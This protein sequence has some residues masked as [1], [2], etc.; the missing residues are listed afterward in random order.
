MNFFLTNDDGIDSPNLRLLAEMT[1]PFG[2]V[3]VVAPEKQ[4]S[5]MSQHITVRGGLTVKSVQYPVEGVKA[6]TVSGTPAD[7]VKVGLRF[8]VEEKPDY[9]FSGINM[10]INTGFDMCYSGT[11]AAALEGAMSGVPSIAWSTELD[12]DMG[13]TKRYFPELCKLLLERKPEKGHLWNVNFPGIPAAECKGYLL[14]RFPACCAHYG[15]DYIP[16]RRPDGSL[17]LDTVPDMNRDAEEGSDLHAV[18]NGYVAVG[19]FYNQVIC[20]K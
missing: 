14:D 16:E 10:G 20:Y 15:D 17:F 4:C 18:L 11:V 3:T 9:L 12:G 1:L 5:A 13:A 8:C 19:D 2:T 7:C 6:Y